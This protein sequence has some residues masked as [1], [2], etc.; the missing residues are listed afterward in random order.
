MTSFIQRVN[1]I[2]QRGAYHIDQKSQKCEIVGRKSKGVKTTG[3]AGML[4]TAHYESTQMD[5]S[6]H[7]FASRSFKLRQQRAT[8][9]STLGAGDDDDGVEQ[10][11]PGG[12]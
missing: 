5:S 2:W 3:P 8:D 11:T 9:S 6:S 1:T 4:M 7:L 12:P 10:K